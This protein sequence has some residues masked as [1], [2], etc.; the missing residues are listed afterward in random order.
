[1]GYMLS[2][3]SQ[4]KSYLMKL[5]F[6]FVTKLDAFWVQ[7]LHSKYKVVDICPNNIDKVVCSYVWRLLGKVWNNFMDGIV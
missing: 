3:G 2:R 7:V 6:H 1:M 4:N 5:A